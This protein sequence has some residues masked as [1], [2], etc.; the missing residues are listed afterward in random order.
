M[1]E[2]IGSRESDRDLSNLPEPSVLDVAGVRAILERRDSSRLVSERRCFLHGR[3]DVLIERLTDEQRRAAEVLGE[4]E[5]LVARAAIDECG[6][7]DVLEHGNTGTERQLPARE[8]RSEIYGGV[9]E[10]ELAPGAGTVLAGD[11]AVSVD[12]LERVRNRPIA[13]ERIA[14]LVALVAEDD[15]RD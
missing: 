6:D 12:V 4:I 14:V 1:R 5:E 11:R 13:A 8:W 9:A 3:I 7:P 10:H 2:A 15:R